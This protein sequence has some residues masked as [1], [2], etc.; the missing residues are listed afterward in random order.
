MAAAQPRLAAGTFGSQAT[1]SD[2][3]QS[4]YIGAFIAGNQHPE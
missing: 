1:L 3:S 2:G 4:A